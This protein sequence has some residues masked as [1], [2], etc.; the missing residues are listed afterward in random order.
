MLDGSLFYKNR[1]WTA[2]KRL[3]AEP[4]CKKCV[5]HGMGHW[6][7]LPLSCDFS[8]PVFL[9]YMHVSNPRPIL[10]TVCVES[11]KPLSYLA[12]FFLT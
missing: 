11:V 12:S 1:Q 10:W 9:C 3:Q 8:R 4:K 2:E 7:H 6:F 5:F